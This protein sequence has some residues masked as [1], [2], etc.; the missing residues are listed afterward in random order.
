MVVGYNLAASPQHSPPAEDAPPPSPVSWQD[1]FQSAPDT[2]I[3]T[4]TQGRARHERRVRQLALVRVGPEA[5][6]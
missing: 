4:E 3:Q 5:P 1:G 2:D 6:D